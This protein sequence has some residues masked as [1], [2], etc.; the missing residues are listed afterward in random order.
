MKKYVIALAAVLL[1]AGLVIFTAVSMHSRSPQGTATEAAASGSG[2][3][4]VTG[5]ALTTAPGAASA[6][7]AKK[8]ADPDDPENRETADPDG[9]APDDNPAEDPAAAADDSCGA[10]RE[11]RENA[12]ISPS[13]D[14][15][16]KKEELMR[17]PEPEQPEPAVTAPN[18][19]TKPRNADDSG[20]LYSP[21]QYTIPDDPEE[22][23]PEDP[24]EFA[25]EEMPIE[26]N[27]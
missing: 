1:S 19:T 23:P 2:T 24:D 6:T 11:D 15:D 20:P 21:E 26:E 16:P 22:A 13:S 12:Q 8:S 5:T 25:T 9:E 7:T 17:Q 3:T 10:V 14:R 18:R 4:A 27:D